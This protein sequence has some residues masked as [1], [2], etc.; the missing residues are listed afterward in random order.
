VRLSRFAVYAWGV[1]V[2][3]IGVILW[4]AY[5][6]ASGSGAGC[7]SHWPACNGE[8]IHL[9]RQVEAMIELSHRLTSGVA[10]VLVVGLLVWAFRAFPRGHVVRLGAMLSIVFIIAEAL[11][12]AGLVLFRLTARDDSATRAISL[13]LHL[14]N[15]FLLL[16]ALTLTAWWA[17][18]GR[19]LRLRGQG[20]LTWAFLGAAAA[21]MAL[22]ATGAV[23]AL[24]D[25]L[26]P[27]GSLAEGLQQDLSPTA[28]FL[29]QLRVVHPVLAVLVGVYGVVVGALS[30]VLRRGA[31]TR[32]LAYALAAIFV[33]QFG[34]GVL[35]LSLLAPIPM[36][37]LHLLMADLLWIVLVLA[38][39]AALAA[40]APVAA[41]EPAADLALQPGAGRTM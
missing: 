1:L 10:L 8:V 39:A 9:P 13:A 14:V 11:I 19:P 18:G 6:R 37:L 2:Y 24:G 5:V 31:T 30:S 23:T 29:I 36:Q 35:N 20:G 7:G 32:R 34:V 27:A 38:A 16:G 12:G 22:G 4:G 33:A 3:N 21:T 28:H 17:S 15:T 26:F 25:T 41:P 40:P